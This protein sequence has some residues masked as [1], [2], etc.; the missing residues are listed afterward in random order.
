[1]RNI[2]GQPQA[3]MIFYMEVNSITAS[4]LFSINQSISL[5][6]CICTQVASL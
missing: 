6:Y 3:T 1:V 5:H 4:V 2:N